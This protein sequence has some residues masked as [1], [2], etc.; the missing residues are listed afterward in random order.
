MA[1]TLPQPEVSLT[2][3]AI[4]SNTCSA[5]F[6][7]PC[8][9]SCATNTRAARHHHLNLHQKVSHNHEITMKYNEITLITYST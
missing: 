9:L 7:L 6:Y 2:A 3:M 5:C 4:F 1:G 8:G